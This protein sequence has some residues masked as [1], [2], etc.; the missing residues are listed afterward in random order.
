LREA[1]AS[2]VEAALYRA[3]VATG[4]IGD[5]GVALP[6][7]LT[8]H[9][10]GAVVGGELPDALIHRFL[11]VALA[12]QIVRPGGR[13]LE[14]ER[15]VVGLPVFFDR[16]EQDERV[17]T[18]VAELVLGQVRG[19][20]IDPGGELLRLVETV[21]MAEDPDEYLLHQVLGPLTVPDRAV[22][23]VEQSG[24]VAVDERTERLGV[25]RQV[26]E[27]EPAVVQL[28]ERLALPRARGGR[29]WGLLF[30]GN[31][32]GTGSVVSSRNVPD[33]R[34][35]RSVVLRLYGTNRT[36]SSVLPSSLT[37][38]R[39]SLVNPG[40]VRMALS[41]SSR[42]AVTPVS[43]SS[44]RRVQASG[45]SPESRVPAGISHR[46]PPAA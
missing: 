15:P 28:V 32:H 26:L 37:T 2:P 43:S 3:Q 45:A 16:L 35:N 31:S 41:R 24:L 20:R 23:E 22:D 11:E 25:A 21:Q 9:E 7:E 42:S 29:G 17:A 4:D 10:D 13:V 8:Q 18:A 27:H 1:V 12:V 40:V 5:L 14:L 44:S 38:A 36:R 39:P 34:E 19:D 30:E 33:L 6:F 46:G